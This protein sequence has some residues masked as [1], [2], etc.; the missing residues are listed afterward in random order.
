MRLPFALAAILL[1]AGP[2]CS[3]RPRSAAQRIAILQVDNLSGDTSLDWI[4]AA[5]PRILASQLSG[6][7]DTT[8]LLANSA[9]DAYA[10]GATRLLRG[11]FDDRDAA[12]NG[13]APLHFEFR[14]EDAASHHMLEPIALDGNPI[15][16]LD[17]LAHR[18]DPS[19]HAF[20]S[21]NPQAVEAFGHGEYEHAVQLDPD[22]SAAWL[23]WAQSFS[24][25]EPAKASDIITRALERSGLR[26]PADRFRLQL[27]AA[28]LNHDPEA[29]LKA[30]QGLESQSSSDPNAV[31]S[32]AETAMNAR[33]F[34]AAAKY[35]ERLLALAPDD[36]SAQNLLGYAY[37][38]GGDLES[39]MKAFAIYRRE[40]G[41]E[42]NALDSM[43][44]AYFV[45]GRFDEAEKYFLQAQDKDPAMLAGGD[46][47][48]AAYARWLAGDLTAADKIYA[49]FTRVREQ[50]K[51]PLLP[52]KEAS[53]LYTTGRASRAQTILE[54]ALPSAPPE[55]A[56]LIRR[57]Q[58][59]WKAPLTIPTDL[60]V[61]KKAYLSTMPSTDGL[62][63]TFYAAALF[64]Q[65]RKDEAHK[66][67][68]LWPLPDAAG[69]PA[70]QGYLYPRFLELREKL[71]G[72]PSN[73]F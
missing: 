50:S 4:A 70:L 15:Q 55:L 62:A 66:L 52:W 26:S 29:E 16:A 8:P 56:A 28:S 35:Y 17:N 34:K 32:L 48:K 27:L 22:F 41:Q 43:A 24:A 44:E 9:S 72:K 39:A 13:S 18:I 21:S 19:A 38:F 20:S 42:A 51:D 33:E 7:P 49:G 5:A 68:A 45:N 65:G 59:V 67:T 71:Y 3:R 53:W 61:L 1:V 58:A 60:A 36:A 12:S 11:Y 30:L 47:L 64:E 25:T 46:L 73:V 69:D 37:A 31:R 10:A 14:M 63:R 54:A 57:Q 23:A 6:V 40:P 2:A